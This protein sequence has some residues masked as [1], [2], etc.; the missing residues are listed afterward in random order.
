MKLFLVRHAEPELMEYSGFPGPKLSASG[1]KQAEYIASLLMKENIDK[2]FISDYLRVIETI[3]PFIN[4][5]P[6]T[7]IEKIKELREREKES[8]THDNLVQRVFN[9][10]GI[11]LNKFG[12]YNVAIFSHCGPINMI[13]QYLDPNHE[14]LKYPFVC[15]YGCFTPKG[16][17]WKLSI[18]S[19][20]KLLEGELYF[21][22]FQNEFEELNCK[23]GTTGI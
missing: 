10:F 3:Q 22:K 6:G 11:N 19:D 5:F 17:L 1:Y 16:G 18:D 23:N 21:N 15:K 9:W 2:I 7:N 20:S 14:K 4:I 8:E 12:N 13:L